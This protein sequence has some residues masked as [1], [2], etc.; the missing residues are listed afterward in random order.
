MA[1]HFIDLAEPLDAY[2]KF[3]SAMVSSVSATEKL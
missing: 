1:I 3:L 2:T